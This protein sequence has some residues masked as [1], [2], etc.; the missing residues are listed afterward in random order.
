MQ[1]LVSNYFAKSGKVLVKRLSDITS[2]IMQCGSANTSLISRQLSKINGNSFKT[3]DMAIYRLL[4]NK[5]FQIDDSFFRQHVNLIFD[6]LEQRQV[7]KKGSQ[8]QI[9]VDFTSHE[10]NFLILS[11]SVILNDKAITLYFSMRKYPKKKNQIS[12]I[13]ME[14]AFVKGLRHILSKKYSYV[15]VADR[16]FGNDRFA[17]LCT[18]NNFDYVLRLNS[19]LSLKRNNK[20]IN[21]KTLKQDEVFTAQVINWKKDVNI[22]ICSKG[23]KIWYL[24]GSNKFIKSK[25]AY[26]RRFKIEKNYQDCKSSGYDIENNKIRKYDRFKRLLYCVLLAH[27]LTSIIGH[28]ISTSGT[29]IKKNSYEREKMDIYLILACSKLDILLS[30][31]TIKNPLLYFTKQSHL[32]NYVG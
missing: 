15:I 9:N 13:K 14:Q 17:T 2:A 7:I 31:S 23:K 16:G 22:T 3:N 12:Q 25:P 4:H 29:A 8:I 18:E 6:L 5:N 19:N 24:M 32:H 26:E 1:E 10:D 30:P 11:A 20:K 27:T 21:L 28:V